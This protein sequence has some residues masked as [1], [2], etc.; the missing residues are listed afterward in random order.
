EPYR[1]QP[2]WC[3]GRPPA[4]YYYVLL[5]PRLLRQDLSTLHHSSGA[6]SITHQAQLQTKGLSELS[7][8]PSLFPSLSLQPGSVSSWRSTDFSLLALHCWDRSGSSSF[9]K[10]FQ[11]FTCFP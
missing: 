10:A 1:R 6:L 4:D 3:P 7:Y 2:G 5:I 11:T 8:S 9:N